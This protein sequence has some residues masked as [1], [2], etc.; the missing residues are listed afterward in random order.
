MPRIIAPSFYLRTTSQKKPGLLE[1]WNARL[2]RRVFNNKPFHVPAGSTLS[3]KVPWG[4]QGGDILKINWRSGDG[5][6]FKS[7]G[8]FRAQGSPGRP[9]IDRFVVSESN[10]TPT[11]PTTRIAALRRGRVNVPMR[12]VPRPSLTRRLP[13]FGFGNYVGE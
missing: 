9:M 3:L 12:R 2:F 6:G 1:V 5:R 7:L 11:F 4:T 8:Y 10:L 13:M